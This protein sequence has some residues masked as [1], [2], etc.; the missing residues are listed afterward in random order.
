MFRE[1]KWFAHVINLKEAKPDFLILSSAVTELT[2]RN[3]GIRI[4]ITSSWDLT[5]EDIMH[6][7]SRQ[8]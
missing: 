7:S 2:L 1:I 3:D 5:G 8:A 6:H 4:L